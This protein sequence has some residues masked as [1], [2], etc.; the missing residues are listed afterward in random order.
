MK[1]YSLV[2]FLPDFDFPLAEAARKQLWW[3]AEQKKSDGYDVTIYIISDKKHLFEKNGINIVFI[4][5]KSYRLI[6][7]DV[8]HYIIGIVEIRLL[9]FFLFRCRKRYVTFL[10]GDVFDGG[11]AALRKIITKVFPFFFDR[12]Q[13]I[14]HYQQ[15]Q[16]LKAGCR[17]VTVVPPGLPDFR[18]RRGNA[19]LL[20]RA[21]TLLYMGHL[22]CIK[23]VDML[24][25][26]FEALSRDQDFPLAGEMKLVIANNAIRRA[27][28]RVLG[29]INRLG[30]AGA[31]RVTVKG[32]VDPAAEL[33]R[34][35][36]YVFPLRTIAGT[37]AFPL[38][39]YESVLCETPFIS[40]RVGSI[41]EFFNRDFLVDASPVAIALKVKEILADYSQYKR[42]VKMQQLSLQR[43]LPPGARGQAGPA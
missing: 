36:I 24:L 10:G 15:R 1:T 39:L 13:V 35:W 27:D 21:P 14:S 43:L 31:D 2:S 34:A 18:P 23:G 3:K 38:S 25:E 22:T 12:V 29:M 26:A 28:E 20:S 32:V 30:A 37:M 11:K 5:K 7:T 8:C 19:S 42:A 16:L 4:D 6:R 33:A 9:L 40:T 17:K 41:P